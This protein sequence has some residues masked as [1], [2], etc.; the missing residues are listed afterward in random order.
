MTN[1]LEY[2]IYR[3]IQQDK[4]LTEIYLGYQEFEWLYTKVKYSATCTEAVEFTLFDKTICGLLNIEDALSFEQIGEIL[5]FNV[6]DNP[7]KKKYKDLAE[8]EILREAIQGLE[9]FDMITTGDTSYSYCQLTD[10]GKEY[11]QKGK[12]LK[13]IMI[14][15]LPYILIIRIINIQL[16]KIILSL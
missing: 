12:S 3:A 13:Y 8:S 16:L 15:S 2:N 4:R 11:F 1:D 14:N 5:G 9:E 7:S 6:E 10:I